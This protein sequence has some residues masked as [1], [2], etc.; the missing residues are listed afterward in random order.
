MRRGHGVADAHTARGDTEA[1]GL[2]A[3]GFP[4]PP[5]H[6]VG[7]ADVWG[8]HRMVARGRAGNRDGIPVNPSYGG[9]T[10]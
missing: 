5:D 3:N 8:A 4:S 1:A 9:A 2:V 10:R 6:A 7:V